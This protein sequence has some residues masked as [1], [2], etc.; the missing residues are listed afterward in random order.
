[1]RFMLEAANVKSE[2]AAGA[3]KLQGL[4]FAWMRVVEVWLRTTMRDSRR[5]WPNSIAF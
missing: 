5:R 1:M 4:V 2:G 3:I